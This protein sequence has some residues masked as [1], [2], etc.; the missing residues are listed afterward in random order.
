VSSY[1]DAAQASFDRAQSAYDAQLPP[2]GEEEMSI[3][4]L[5][6]EVRYLIGRNGSG[7]LTD[8]VTALLDALDK[9][10]A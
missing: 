1:S 8:A 10:G 2:E 6:D 9:G 4:E 7:E 5:R 3:D